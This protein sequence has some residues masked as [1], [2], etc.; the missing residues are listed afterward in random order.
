MKEHLKGKGKDPHFGPEKTLFKLQEAVLEVAGP[1]TCLWADLLNKEASISKEDTVLL[2]QRALV[3][4]GNVSHQMT[5]ERRK[6]AWAKINAKLKSLASE[7]YSKRGT[8]LF[9]SGFLE[10]ASKRLEV[11]R[12]MSKVSLPQPSNPSSKRYRYSRNSSDLRSFLSKGAPA[13]HGGRKFQR[14]QPYSSF[15]KSFQSRKY[16]QRPPKTSQEKTEKQRT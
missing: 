10:M 12:T 16:F 5:L 9:G 8:N 3:L 1:L 15:P 13:Q 2:A 4:L 6:I 11:D 7:D 14:H